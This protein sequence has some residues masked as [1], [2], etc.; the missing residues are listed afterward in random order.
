MFRNSRLSQLSPP[1]PYED[2]TFGGV[3]HLPVVF[4]Y[5]LSRLMHNDKGLN[6]SQ[7]KH[8]TIVW[9]KF[10]DVWRE[11]TR[12][13]Q[14]VVPRTRVCI[15]NSVT[16]MS[17]L[18]DNWKIMNWNVIRNL[19]SLRACVNFLTAGDL[20]LSYYS[21]A[22]LRTSF[23]KPSRFVAPFG[24]FMC[25]LWD[26]DT[27]LVFPSLREEQSTLAIRTGRD[28]CVSFPGAVR[29]T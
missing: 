2:W 21:K 3:Q 25:C 6:A 11:Q 12:R 20:P 9:F 10:I 28:E 7:G 15:S 27:F 23:W 24:V 14:S 29:S 13:S 26:R 17:E 4:C 18:L 16:D 8:S 22:V 19:F 1:S 5:N